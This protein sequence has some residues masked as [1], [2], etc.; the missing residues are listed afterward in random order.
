MA[1]K[2]ERMQT[3]LCL[4]AMAVEQIFTYTKWGLIISAVNA[5]ISKNA[6]PAPIAQASRLN[7][8]LSK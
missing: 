2:Q 8:K 6:S 1:E 5:N 3:N 4:P 7:L